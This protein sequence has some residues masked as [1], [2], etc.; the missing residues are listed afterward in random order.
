LP[1]N[2][3]H[4]HMILRVELMGS[5]GRWKR[6]LPSN[7]L[8]GDFSRSLVFGRVV[9]ATCG[10]QRVRVGFLSGRR[11]QERD[12]SLLKNLDYLEKKDDAEQHLM[13]TYHQA[14]YSFTC[15]TVRPNTPVHL[16]FARRHPNVPDEKVANRKGSRVGGGRS[17]R[18]FRDA[19]RF[20]STR[21]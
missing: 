13:Q 12:D 18:P 1:S 14:C 7:S 20:P 2:S 17:T 3:P 15:T 4:D 9:E 19:R 10:R 6:P 21:W 8:W 16:A 11:V 5:H